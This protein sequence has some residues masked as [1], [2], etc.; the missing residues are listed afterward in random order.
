MSG[1]TGRDSVGFAFAKF[2]A[3]SWGVPASVTRGMYFT[4]DGG[5]THQV[6]Y[7]DD[8][9][10]GQP[11]LGQ[12]EVGDIAPI[13]AQLTTRAK[14]AGFDHHWHALAMGSPAA[15]TISTSAAGQ[16]TSWLHVQDTAPSIDGLGLTL[17]WDTVLFVN[18]VTSAKVVG[19]TETGGDGGVYDV[20]FH[21]VGNQVTKDSTTNTRS[22]VAGATFPAL[23]NRIYRKHATFRL[24]AQGAGSLVAANALPVENWT[25]EFDRAQ[26]TPHVTG[27]AFIMEPADNDFPMP[28]VRVNFPR[29]NT[30]T[31]NSLRTFLETGGILKGDCTMAG[32]FINSTDRYTKRYQWPHMECQE[33]SAPLAGANQVKPTAL[34]RLKRPDTSVTSAAGMPFVGPFRLSYI[35][36]QSVVPF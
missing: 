24:N 14:Y 32:N 13:D 22:T 12:A 25:F 3:N 19:W 2:G 11:F 28:N 29:M 16:T 17:A 20:T 1:V 8:L 7:V 5:I 23:V 15:V 26:D 31:A 35:T 21:I 9:A 18:E 36:T 34:F 33:W 27:Q 6:T 30:I 10:F 4:G